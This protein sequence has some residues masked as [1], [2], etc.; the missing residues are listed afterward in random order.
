MTVDIIGAVPWQDR[1][2]D[3]SEPKDTKY[4]A[5]SLVVVGQRK[6]RSGTSLST[7][8]IFGRDLGEGGKDFFDEGLCKT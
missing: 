2:E 5:R 1:L 3:L 6:W 8:M 4:S 7:A